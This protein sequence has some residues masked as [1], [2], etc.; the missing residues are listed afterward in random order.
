MIIPW[1]TDAPLY[2]PPFA[3]VGLI[4]I[5]VLVFAVTLRAE[6]TVAEWALWHGD[7]LHPLQWITSNFIHGGFMHLIG[8]MIFLWGF[9][10]VVEGKL[11]WQRFLAVFFGIGVVQCAVEQVCAL[12]L[13]EGLSFG[14][15]AIIYGL[16]AISLVWAPK[17][18][19]SCLLILGFRVFTFD[20][21]IMVLASI[22]LAIEVAT[23]IYVQLPISSAVLHLSGALLGLA[24]GVTM[25]KMNWVDCENCDI[26]AVMGDRVGEKPKKKKSPRKRV[27]AEETSPERESQT[28]VLLKAFRDA[29]ASGDVEA[30][31]ALRN[32]IG[33]D[34]PD[35]GLPEA[36]LLAWIQSLYDRREW[37]DS[38]AAMVEFLKRFPDKSVRVRLKLAHLL[39]VELNRPSQALR[40]LQ[41]LPAA[42]LAQPLQNAREKLVQQ[43]TQMQERAAT[44]EVGLEDW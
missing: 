3:T 34:T 30:A 9:G 39:V 28:D 5:N 11:G 37:Q 25:L 2:H 36:D 42:P 7:G 24:V 44:F 33:R 26:F 4:A 15:S 8:N 10:L 38:V 31:K 27:R 1:N 13:E 12:W 21:S 41:K 18:E 40:V 32:K 22:Y 17:N 43:A 19:M 14:A 16:L 6:D 29:L 23:A 20:L 35:R